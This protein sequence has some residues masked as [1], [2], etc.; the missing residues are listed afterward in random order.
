MPSGKSTAGYTKGAQAI[1]YQRHRDVKLK[2]REERRENHIQH[3]MCEGI[4]DRCREKVQWKFN[5]GKYKSLTR[6]G[7]CRDCKNKTVT[8]AYRSWCD[9]CASKD[10]KCA[11]CGGNIVELNNERRIELEKRSLLDDG[12]ADGAQ[13]GADGGEQEIAEVEKVAGDHAAG[14]ADVLDE[15]GENSGEGDEEI[16]KDE[17]EKTDSPQIESVFHVT[18]RD[19]RKLETYGASKYSKSRVTGS[20]ADAAMVENFS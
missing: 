4:C 1:K 3:A 16:T 10:H 8:K 6:P 7:S 18:D 15:D 20:A 13:E 14:E 9:S 11:A 2:D 12:S 19:L 17:G 5:Y